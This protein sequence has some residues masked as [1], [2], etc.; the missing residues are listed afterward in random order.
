MG[1]VEVAWLAIRAALEIGRVGFCVFVADTLD[2]G[3]LP[4]GAAP[5]G[6]RD[7]RC[8]SHR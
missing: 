2:A 8:V 1:E 4:I 6:C 5:P 7:R 3:G